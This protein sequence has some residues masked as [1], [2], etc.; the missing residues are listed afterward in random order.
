MVGGY[1]I[2]YHF[3]NYYIIVQNNVHKRLHLT[4][5][6]EFHIGDSDFA[7]FVNDV[8]SFSNHN[9]PVYV[10]PASNE[11]FVTGDGE[12]INVLK[13][14]KSTQISNMHHELMKIS[15]RYDAEFTNIDYT[16]DGFNPHLSGA[17][18]KTS[19]PVFNRLL[20]SSFDG[21]NFNILHTFY[22]GSPNKT[23]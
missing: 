11:V 1:I 5:I 3:N 6:P 7:H 17:N 20:I 18:M 12:K 10:K 8:R 13:L 22:L 23:F 2:L 4:L 9:V 15:A 19:L 21:E 16:G 14:Q